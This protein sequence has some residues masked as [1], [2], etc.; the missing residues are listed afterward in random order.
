MKHEIKDRAADREVWQ[1]AQNS[2]RGLLLQ[3]SLPFPSLSVYCACDIDS[4]SGGQR[5]VRTGLPSAILTLLSLKAENGNM[6]G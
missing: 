2:L 5:W 3:R 1:L 4:Y 6:R